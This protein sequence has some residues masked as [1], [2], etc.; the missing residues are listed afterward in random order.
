MI[1][2]IGGIQI[3]LQLLHL[4]FIS[5]YNNIGPEG[6]KAIAEGLKINRKLTELEISF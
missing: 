4:A 2:D 5:P 1:L 3:Q 6:A